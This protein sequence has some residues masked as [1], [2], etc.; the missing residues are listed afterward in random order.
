MYHNNNFDYIFDQKLNNTDTTLLKKLQ[1]IEYVDPVQVRQILFQLQYYFSVH[2]IVK[3]SNIN[4]YVEAI[5]PH[6]NLDNHV[7]QIEFGCLCIA[8]LFIH[9]DYDISHN[10]SNSLFENM[11]H[12]LELDNEVVVFTVLTM[13]SK[14]IKG[15]KIIIST[16]LEVIT[17]ELLEKVICSDGFSN[18]KFSFIVLF[19]DIVSSGYVFSED[20]MNTFI[21]IALFLVQKL[22]KQDNQTHRSASKTDKRITEITIDIV[23]SMRNIENWY[24]IFFVGTDL[25]AY[26]NT[27]LL[28]VKSSHIRYK[29]L[30]LISVIVKSPF[31]DFNS[32]DISKIISCFNHRN[33]SIKLAAT[34]CV[35]SML[36]F[37]QDYVINNLN[38]GI[39]N[40][41]MSIFLNTTQNNKIQALN[42]LNALIDNFSCNELI[43]SFKCGF[44]Q[45]LIEMLLFVPTC[46]KNIVLSIFIKICAIFCNSELKSTFVDAFCVSGGVDVI[47]E[48]INSEDDIVSNLATALLD[49]VTNC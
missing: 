17:P 19:Y 48:L 8:A 16:I 20:Q 5:L 39:G 31:C 22:V 18:Y 10:I 14:F 29:T 35:E 44:L 15:S 12:L 47:V 26:I 30:M 21:K 3:C 32:F 1:S 37:A 13:C 28:S 43:E 41:I 45:S 27:H 4:E 23:Y 9:E 7:S 40:G 11:K 6:I 24:K 33:N 38:Q 2:P 46:K 49:Y 42:S 36:V 25:I 34:K